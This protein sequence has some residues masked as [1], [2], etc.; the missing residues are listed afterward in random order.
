MVVALRPAQ[1]PERLRAPL[2]RAEREG[3]CERF[4]LAPLSEAE[5][6]ELLARRV[7]RSLRALGQRE[8]G[9][10]ELERD[11]PAARRWG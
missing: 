11:R 8:R 3:A 6:W 4:E 5:A 2:A 10:A 1:A 7:E 9:I